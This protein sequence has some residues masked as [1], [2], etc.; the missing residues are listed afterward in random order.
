MCLCDGTWLFCLRWWGWVHLCIS[1]ETIKVA[2]NGLQGIIPALLP[3][4]STQ[5]QRAQGPTGRKDDR[6]DVQEV[7]RRT[8]GLTLLSSLSFCFCSSNC[9]L[10]LSSSSIFCCC[11]RRFL[12]GIENNMKSYMRSNTF[13]IDQEHLSK[14][15]MKRLTWK[16]M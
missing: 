7:E 16:G 15:R 5:R 6:L 8:L 13:K 1:A 3:C 2:F 9:L 12:K 4:L 14:W 11:S 10:F